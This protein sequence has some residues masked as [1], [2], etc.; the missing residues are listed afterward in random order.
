MYY[1]LVMVFI[2]AILLLACGSS[3]IQPD[4][5]E[6][7]EQDD[8]ETNEQSV[9]VAINQL[10]Y[11]PKQTKIAVVGKTNLTEF[12]VVDNDSG[13]VRFTNSLTAATTWDAAGNKAFKIADFSDFSQL[14]KFKLVIGEQS[15][16]A[17]FEIHDAVYDALHSAVLKSYFYNR[18][19]MAVE[20][21]YT[22]THVRAAGHPDLDVLVHDSAASSQ[23]PP[24]TR[25]AAAKGWYDAGDYGK[26][27]VNSGITMFTLLSAF[28]HFPEVYTN[29][30]VGIP[31]SAD[32]IPD[33]L[34]EIRW[35]LE[36]MLT[37][38]DI[39][40]G[41]YHKLTTLGWPGIE[42]PNEDLRERYVIGKST[43]AS[44]DF[45]ATMALAHRVYGEQYESQKTQ[46][47]WLEA[48][49]SAWR[50]ALAN[51]NVQY[52]QPFDV[53]SGEYGD[54]SLIHI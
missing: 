36:W 7:V 22:Q 24:G 40:G 8:S 1:R 6:K 29:L 43:A 51:K 34:N 31:E 47:E 50:W 4:V 2:L 25:I 26:Y 18:A 28:E 49:E 9:L 44:L 52:V 41:V 35:N 11:T 13:E 37:M 17:E 30:D 54:L 48:A 23:R 45:A 10:G 46:L 27:V 16:S 32:G 33:I 42:M 3:G 39:N 15:R 5:G 21:P 53:S 19:G 14:G 12:S 20:M 38:Q